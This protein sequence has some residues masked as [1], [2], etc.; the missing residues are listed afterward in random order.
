MESIAEDSDEEYLVQEIVDRREHAAESVAEPENHYESQES[1]SDDGTAAIGEE[2]E[3]HEAGLNLLLLQIPMKLAAPLPL[4]Q[5]NYRLWRTQM[6]LSL[7]LYK[8]R[9]NLSPLLGK[10]EHHQLL[11]H[12][13]LQVTDNNPPG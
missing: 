8:Y 5:K 3:L 1:S 2:S 10:S 6:T 11:L 13:G 7:H 4:M 9:L 12:A